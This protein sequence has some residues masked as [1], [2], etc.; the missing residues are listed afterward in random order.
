MPP[1]DPKAQVSI[2][3]LIPIRVEIHSNERLYLYRAKYF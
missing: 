2:E 1:S 3:K